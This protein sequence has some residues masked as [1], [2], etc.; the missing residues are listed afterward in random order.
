V[1][2]SRS[3][4]PKIVHT[5]FAVRFITIVGLVATALA[6]SI[7]PFAL[8]TKSSAPEWN[9]R[10]LSTFARNPLVNVGAQV[11]APSSSMPTL[12]YLNYTGL[13]NQN[14]G[15]LEWGPQDPYPALF[16]SLE[17]IDPLAPIVPVYFQRWDQG[18]H[19]WSSKFSFTPQGQLLFDGASKFYVKNLG[20]PYWW[21][22]PVLFWG[23]GDPGS[24]PAV[25]NVTVWRYPAS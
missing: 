23:I 8:Y 1:R 16:A 7:G 11:S 20:N 3:T 14:T 4:P 2:Y 12:F 22:G 17:I 6:K 5:M 10:A 25:G 24:D 9:N 18:L 19:D 13:A 15:Y 21:G